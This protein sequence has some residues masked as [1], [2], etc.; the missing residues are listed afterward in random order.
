MQISE[1]CAKKGNCSENAMINMDGTC[2]KCQFIGGHKQWTIKRL[3]LSIHLDLRLAQLQ[4]NDINFPD[5]WVRD[6]AQDK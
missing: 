4:A 3:Y 6:R 1:H 2:V 5:K